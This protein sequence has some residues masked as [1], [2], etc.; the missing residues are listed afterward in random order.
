MLNIIDMIT[1]RL[2]D[3]QLGTYKTR[4]LIKDV[5]NIIGR[6]RYLEPTKIKSA[7]KR[8]GWDEDILDYRTIELICVFLENQR[9]IKTH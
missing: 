6:G 5:S 2:G 9:M 1:A 3:D 4:R 8:L 7:L